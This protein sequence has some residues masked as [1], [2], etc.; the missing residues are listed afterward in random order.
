M[1]DLHPLPPH[2][3]LV[4]LTVNVMRSLYDKLREVASRRG[5]NETEAIQQ[6]LAVY[7]FIDETLKN[8]GTFLIADGQGL[9]PVFFDRIGQ[10]APPVHAKTLIELLKELAES[11]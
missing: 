10:A 8:G 7:T 5:I 9:R 2:P 11:H 1:A 3:L 6:A 4:K